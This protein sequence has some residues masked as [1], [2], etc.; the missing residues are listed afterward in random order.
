MKVGD[1]EL[2]DATAQLY[3]SRLP[4]KSLARAGRFFLAAVL[5]NHTYIRFPILGLWGVDKRIG[6]DLPPPN[7]YHLLK[8]PR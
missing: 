3:G 1:H 2:P 7:V 5:N 8:T 4:A 6:A